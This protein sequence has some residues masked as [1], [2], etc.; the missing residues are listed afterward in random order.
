MIF[1]G[2]ALGLVILNGFFVAAEFAVVKVRRTRLEELA[3]QARQPRELRCC[4]S[5]T[6]TNIYRRPS[7]ASLWSAWHSAGSAKRAFTIC[8]D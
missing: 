5:I 4:W 8:S 6:S 1:V 3:G 2:V 7:S